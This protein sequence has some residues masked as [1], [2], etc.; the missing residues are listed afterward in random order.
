MKIMNYVLKLAPSIEKSLILTD[1]NNISSELKQST[2]PVY[3]SAAESL[4]KHAFKDVELLKFIKIFE[5]E[6]KTAFKGNFLTIIY[7]VSKQLDENVNH[8]GKIAELVFSNEVMATGIS[9]KKANLL[10]YIESITFFQR[11]ARKL[12]L[13]VYTA[14]TAFVTVGPDTINGHMTPGDLKWL[15]ENAVSFVKLLEPLSLKTVQLEKAIS[16][17]P[18]IAVSADTDHVVSSTQGSKVDPFRMS[19]ISARINLIYIARKHF[20]EIQDYRYKAAMQ[21]RKAIEFRL[22]HLQNKLDG[23]NDANVEQQIEYNVGRLEKLNYKIQK[24]E[25]SL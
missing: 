6:E 23:K 1:I 21:E 14:E 11:Y 4:G 12:L 15:A 10:Q 25:D 19:F 9:Y 8:L 17:I 2:L 18:D 13:W 20:A 5:R 22:L 7:E 24:Y 3:K 16:D